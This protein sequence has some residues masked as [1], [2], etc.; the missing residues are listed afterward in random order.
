MRTRNHVGKPHLD[1]VGPSKNKDDDA[2]PK[3]FKGEMRQGYTHY[4]W[5]FSRASTVAE[6]GVGC[7]DDT[8]QGPLRSPPSRLGVDAHRTNSDLHDTP[9]TTA[10]NVAREHPGNAVLQHQGCI[11]EMPEFTA[12]S[13]KVD[14]LMAQLAVIK[15]LLLKRDAGST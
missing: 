12:V 10:G 14:A 5:V 9:T 6:L 7:S 3:P 1:A 4:R 11:N 8:A 2:W 13:S 15:E